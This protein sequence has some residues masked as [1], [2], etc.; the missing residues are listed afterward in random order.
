MK[1]KKIITISAYISVIIFGIIGC[2]F[3]RYV[4]H[5]DMDMCMSHYYDYD[6]CNSIINESK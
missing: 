3:M 2:L 5:H 1:D 6:Y 4:L